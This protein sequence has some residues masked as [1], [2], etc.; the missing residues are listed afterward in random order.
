MTWLK[1]VFRLTGV[2]ATCSCLA[3]VTACTTAARSVS[4]FANRTSEPPLTISWNYLRPGPATVVAE[5]LARNDLPRKFQFV[6]V[7]ASLSGFD[8]Q[9]GLVSRSVVR[10][11]DFVAPETPFRITLSLR[12]REETFGLRFEYKAEDIETNGGR[13]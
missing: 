10:V 5:G 7:W 13:N 11:P 1:T 3:L 9:G 2:A 6:D 12:G 8:V 4:G